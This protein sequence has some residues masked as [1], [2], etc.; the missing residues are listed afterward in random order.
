MLE[1]LNGKGILIHH[2][3]TDGIC[4]ARLLLEHLS[5]KDIINRTPQLGYYYLTDEEL[6]EYSKYDFVIVVDMSLTED[7]IL[8]LSKNAQVMIFDHHLGKVYKNI[9]HHNPVIKGENPDDYPSASWIINDYLGNDENLFAILGILGDHEQK[10]KNNKKFMEIIDD[11][12]KNN[13]LTFDDLLKMVYLL[14]S[15]YKLGDKEIVEE[16]PHQL[17]SHGSA[18]DILNNKQWNENYTKLDEELTKQLNM[19]ADEV[20]E[21]IL[22]KINT[23]YN[24]ISTIT[25]KIAWGSGKNTIVINTGFYHDKDQIYMRSKKNAE[26]IISRGKSLGFKCGGKKEV[27]G[28]IVPKDKTDSFVEE[29]LDFL[30]GD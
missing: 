30:I 22:K 25:R 10:I 1:K 26:P 23:P 24:I 14:D 27:L 16:A 7:N 4:S 9:L 11:Y 12:C 6:E 17:L 28:A 20:N 3:D 18:E 8:R 15:N 29:I 13:N 19:P 2:W 5:D 21:I